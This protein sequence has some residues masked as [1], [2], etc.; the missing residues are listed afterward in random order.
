MAA[1]PTSPK[2]SPVKDSPQKEEEEEEDSS[3]TSP[4]QVLN[5]ARAWLSERIYA[6][7]GASAAPAAAAARQ[8]LRALNEAPLRH[9]A[10]VRADGSQPSIASE[11]DIPIAP[12][13]AGGGGGGVSR[14][15][16]FEKGAAGGTGSAVEGGTA[17]RACVTEAQAMA[18][19]IVDA[20]RFDK[21]TSN[22]ARRATLE[23]LLRETAAKGGAPTNSVP[24]HAEVNAMLARSPE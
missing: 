5:V 23:E 24:S 19:E 13:R 11:E 16:S 21:R 18:A 9:Q 14:L 20:G 6:A 10:K 22:D 17:A 3:P 7:E 1:Q 12:S 2:L 15:L 8:G 4:L